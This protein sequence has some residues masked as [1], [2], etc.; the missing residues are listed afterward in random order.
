MISTL[1]LLH[2]KW[3]EGFITGVG[4]GLL[5]TGVPAVTFWTLFG[6]PKERMIMHPPVQKYIEMRVP[7]PDPDAP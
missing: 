4:T 2:K 6:P 1:E 5:L 3:R 7:H